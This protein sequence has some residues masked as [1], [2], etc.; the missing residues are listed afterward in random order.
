MEIDPFCQKV[1]KK[2]WPDVPI[3]SDIKDFDGRTIANTKNLTTCQ[4][5]PRQERRVTIAGCDCG[6]QYETDRESCID[7]ITGGFPCQP[8]S[9]AGK[10]RGKDDDRALWPEMYRVIRE[11]RPRWILGENVA[12]FINLGLDQSIADLEMEGYDV[13][14]FVIPACSVNAPHRRDRVW[15]VANTECDGRGSRGT[16][17]QGLG[18]RAAP[19]GTDRHAADTA[20]VG[21]SPKSNREFDKEQDCKGETNFPG[22]G[23]EQYAADPEISRLEGINAAGIGC[24]WRW[25]PEYADGRN[26]RW[27]EGWLEAATR[28]CRV[29]DG[30]PRIVDRTNRLKSLGNAIVPQVAAVIMQAIKETE[31]NLKGQT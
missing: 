16:E 21:Q 17:R 2:H 8:Y 10:R 19:D 3:H 28:L 27:T 9:C 14:A 20:I 12:G 11:V 13:Q 18:G 24:T 7:L 6:D 30:L 29:G 25:T 15:I 31:T 22:G 26:E 1:L 23:R 5:G 4:A